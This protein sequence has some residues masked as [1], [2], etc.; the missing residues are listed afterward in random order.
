MRKLV[1]SVY[2]YLDQKKKGEVTF[3][4]FLW[5][6]YPA[7]NK[8]DMLLVNHWVEMYRH[9]YDDSYLKKEENQTSSPDKKVLPASSLNRVKEVF[10]ALDFGSKGCKLIVMQISCLMTSKEATDWDTPSQKSRTSFRGSI[11]GEPVVFT[12][13]SLPSFCSQMTSRLR[14]S[15]H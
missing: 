13:T 3:E 14:D 9:T 7:L 12:F 1:S 6:L 15:T 2:S 8:H 11:E 10:S 4:D 5:R